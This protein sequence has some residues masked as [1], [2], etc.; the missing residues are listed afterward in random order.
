MNI[1]NK[2]HDF[3]LHKLCTLV[4]IKLGSFF[5][6]YIL[7]PQN[8]QLFRSTMNNNSQFISYT[9]EKCSNINKIFLRLKKA[10]SCHALID[11]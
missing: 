5:F 10:L 8:F 3:F 11:K 6:T 1:L 2:L 9:D 7:S 4:I